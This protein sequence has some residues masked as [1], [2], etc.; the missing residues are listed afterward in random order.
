MREGMRGVRGKRG[1]GNNVILIILL[2]EEYWN[3]P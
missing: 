3:R 2:K 1:R